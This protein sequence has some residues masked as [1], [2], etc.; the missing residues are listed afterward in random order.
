[1]KKVDAVTIAHCLTIK[2]KVFL[3]FVC[4]EEVRI[5]NQ[6]FSIHFPLYFQKTTRTD[7]KT[8]LIYFLQ[9]TKKNKRI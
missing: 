4:K 3:D 7:D 6:K 2:Q 5:S 8:I 9:K 1:M